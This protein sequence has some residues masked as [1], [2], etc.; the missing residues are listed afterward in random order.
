MSAGEDA[1]CLAVEAGDA[2]PAEAP[3]WYH[4]QKARGLAVP[5]FYASL[6]PWPE[7]HGTLMN[8]GIQRQEYMAWAADYTYVP[9][10]PNSYDACQWTDR[11]L[12]R[13]LDE[14]LCADNFFRRPPPP[15]IVNPLDVL[16]ENE[17]DAVDSYD[18]YIKHPHLHVHGLRVVRAELVTL[19]KRVF[20]RAKADAPTMGWPAA[21]AVRDRGARYLILKSRTEGL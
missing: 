3:A 21:W 16:E 18:V 13:N 7:L 9:H 11:A 15:V 4:R 20:A 2:T 14:S 6:S 17:R 12:G 1:D 10:I 8:A 5:K 19:R